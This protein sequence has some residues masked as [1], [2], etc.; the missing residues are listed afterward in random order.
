MVAVVVMALA[1]L[2]GLNVMSNQVRPKTDQERQAEEMERSKAAQSPNPAATPTPA[3]VP[4]APSGRT[5]VSLADPNALVLSG[6]GSTLGSPDAK[7]EVVVGFSWTPEVQSDP[8]KVSNAVDALLKTLGSQGRVKIVNVD[9]RPEV[10][11]GVSIEGKV[12][13]PAQ[14]DGTIDPGAAQTVKQAL[15]ATP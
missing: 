7:Q 5:G 3:A 12:I 2:V 14:N 10:P 13:V 9:E 8:T 11:E 1:G 6:A 4:S 15:S